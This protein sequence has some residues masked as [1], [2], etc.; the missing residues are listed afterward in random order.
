M[1]IATG[2]GMFSSMA[3]TLIVVPVFYIVLDDFVEG[4][5]RRLRGGSAP[6]SVTLADERV[7]R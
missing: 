6:R 7:N 2:A 3:L 5:R 1:A 4:I